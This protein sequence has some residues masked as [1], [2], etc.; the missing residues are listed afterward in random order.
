MTLPSSQDP[1]PAQDAAIESESPVSLAELIG[2]D[3]IYAVVDRFYNLIQTHPSLAVP[4]QRVHDWPL[5]KERIAYFWWVSLGGARYRDVSFA[6]VPKHWR[7]GFSEELLDDWK[8]LFGGVVSS[9]LPPELA[10]AWTERAE[11]IGASLVM[12]NQSFGDQ[13]HPI[14]LETIF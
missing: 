3:R 5:H 9:V 13:L 6:V 8:A 11:R 2:K 12:A 7:A 10:D 4:F 1:Q 14:G